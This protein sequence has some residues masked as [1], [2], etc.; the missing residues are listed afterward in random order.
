MLGRDLLFL[1]RFFR[2]LSASFL[3]DRNY[4]HTADNCEWKF[5]VNVYG[6]RSDVSETVPDGA[7]DREVNRFKLDRQ[8]KPVQAM[9]LRDIG[10]D[11]AQ[12]AR[13][14][15]FFSNQLALQLRQTRGEFVR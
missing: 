11:G 7:T 12:S 8:P 13:D 5:E 2:F 1:L 3:V 15:A 14:F 4:Q 10:I 9:A 6:K